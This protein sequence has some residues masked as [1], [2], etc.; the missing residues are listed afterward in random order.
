MYRNHIDYEFTVLIGQ[1]ILI[2][3]M[4][5]KMYEKLIRREI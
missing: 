4:N 2:K 1:V 5:K 3:D